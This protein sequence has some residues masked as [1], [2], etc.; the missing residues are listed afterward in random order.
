MTAP[1]ARCLL[2]KTS[3]KRG[4]QQVAHATAIQKIKRV[5]QIISVGHL[6]YKFEYFLLIVIVGY[7]KKN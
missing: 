6:F 3:I 5:G 2:V 4:T 7:C 1:A